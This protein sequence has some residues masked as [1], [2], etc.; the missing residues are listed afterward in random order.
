MVLGGDD[1]LPQLN[2]RETKMAPLHLSIEEVTNVIKDLDCNKAVGP[3]MV[4]NRL[5]VSAQPLIAEPLTILFNKSLE[6]GVFPDVWK[7]AHVIP[8]YKQKGNRS[9]CKNYRPISLL[10]CVGKIL[11]KCVQKHLVKFLKDHNIITPSQSGFTNGDSTIY[12]LL[13]IYDD[14]LNA[15]DKD[16]PT[17]VVFFDISKAFDRVWHRGLLHKLHAIGIRDSLLNWFENYLTNRTQAVVVK[18]SKSSFLTVSAGVP[19]GSV[20]GPTLFL[21]YINDLNNGIESTTKLFAD[22]TSIYLSLADE[23]NRTRILN[24]DLETINIWAKTWKVS[25]NSQ[26]TELLNICKR[27]TIMDNQLIFDDSVL[28]PSTFHKHL[29]LTLQGNC[30]WDSHVISLVARCQTLVACLKSYKYRLNRKSLEIMYK[31]FVLPHFDYADVVWDNLTQMQI[32]NLEQIQLDALQTIVGTV[33]GTSHEKIYKESGFVPLK[34]R[35]DRHKLI[36]FF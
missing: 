23:L 32:E 22:D 16:I 9:S 10:S 24:T 6:N 26:K 7:V 36:M 21:L 27:N 35:R 14:I 28:Q 17:Q 29:G 33:R 19:Q 8:I 5:I 12:Q 11:E 3:D 34:L 2:V 30:K 25:F 13:N 4:H 20:L 31:S 18:G 15:L 1:P